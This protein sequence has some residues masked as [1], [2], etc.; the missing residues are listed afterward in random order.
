MFINHLIMKV[1]SI[2]LITDIVTCIIITW[3]SYEENMHIQH[4]VFPYKT[5]KK[6]FSTFSCIYQWCKIC[7]KKCMDPIRANLLKQKQKWVIFKLTLSFLKIVV[8][9]FPLF[10][11]LLELTSS[12]LTILHRVQ[13]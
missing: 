4:F 7:K 11:G 5:G 12:Q 13:M 9:S 6:L 2:I 3:C 10:L 8:L 1:S